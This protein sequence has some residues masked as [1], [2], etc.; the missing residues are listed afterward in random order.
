MRNWKLGLFRL[1]GKLKGFSGFGSVSKRRE[2][3]SFVRESRERKWVLLGKE[4]EVLKV[5]IGMA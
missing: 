3:E 4:D 2:R 5:T 1:G